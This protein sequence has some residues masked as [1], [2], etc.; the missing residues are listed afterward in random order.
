M[1]PLIWL[2][3]LIV[4]LVIEFIRIE[5]IGAC[6]AVGALAGLIVCLLGFDTIWQIAAAVALTVFL[7]VA[8]RPVGMKY[9]MRARREKQL[10]E[11]EG[12]DAIVTCRIDNASS[13][14]V[15]RIGG[16]NWRAR[17]NRPNA[18]INEGEVVKVI[19]M[20]GDVAYVDY[21]K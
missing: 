13:S 17:S 18:I 14:G 11:L 8:V 15:V 1:T 21:K 16:R 5:L 9:V 12:C 3:I 7:F 2:I 19:N 4:C 10:M 20:R 6:G